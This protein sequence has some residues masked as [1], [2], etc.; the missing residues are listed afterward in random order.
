MTLPDFACSGTFPAYAP[1]KTKQDQVE[2]SHTYSKI[3]FKP[4]SILVV[5]QTKTKLKKL[6]KNTDKCEF[7]CEEGQNHCCFTEMRDFLVDLV[8]KFGVSLVFLPVSSEASAVQ[9]VFSNCCGEH[10]WSC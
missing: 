4:D 10:P 9:K 1:V 6:E 2:S 8:G 3:N 5:F 7:F